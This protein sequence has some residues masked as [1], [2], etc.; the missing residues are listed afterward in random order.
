MQERFRT[1]DVNVSRDGEN[2]LG[3]LQQ[4]LDNISSRE[5]RQHIRNNRG[6]FVYL[7]SILREAG[8][9]I[10]GRS[11]SLFYKTV[12]DSGIP[13]RKLEVGV[14]IKNGKH[15]P[16]AYDVVCAEHE[17]EIVKILKRNPETQKFMENPVQQVRGPKQ[18]LL[19]SSHDLKKKDFRSVRVL[20]RKVRILVSK[21]RTI[22]KLL[23]PDCPVPVVAYRGR[24]YHYRK[25]QERELKAFLRKRRKEIAQR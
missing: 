19:P 21:T 4:A 10:G 3:K 7:G 11:S 2:N 1:N 24:T 18:D 14:Q 9:H 23:P 6:Q 22:G 5:L 13:I 17:E 15:Y 20:L 16:Q 25:D 8:F 12:S